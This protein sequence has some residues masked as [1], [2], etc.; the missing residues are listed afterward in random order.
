MKK[1][2]SKDDYFFVEKELKKIFLVTEN[3]IAYRGRIMKRLEY[4]ESFSFVEI[5]SDFEKAEDILTGSSDDIDKRLERVSESMHKRMNID[6][7]SV[8][9][10]V[11]NALYL[12][13]NLSELLEVMKFRF[14]AYYGK[15]YLMQREQGH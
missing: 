14:R 10:D 9:E 13:T 5:F 15:S 7:S 6:G 3:Y 8:R 1:T 12:N 4:S 11:V 2:I